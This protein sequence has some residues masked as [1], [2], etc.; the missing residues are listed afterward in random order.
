MKKYVSAALAAIILLLTVYVPSSAV[1][2]VWD[3]VSW[4]INDGVL[5]VSGASIPDSSASAAPPWSVFSDTVTAIRIGDGVTELGAR[6]FKDMSQVTSVELGHVE[7]IGE[8][9]FSGCSALETVSLPDTVRLIGDFSFTGCTSLRE[10]SLPSSVTSVGNN[11]WE[12]C[13]SL[14]SI[15]SASE[16]YYSEN[17]VLFDRAAAAI[18]KFPSGSS[19][20][21]FTAPDGITSVA[22]GAF[23]DAVNMTSVLLPNVATIA[24][25]AFYGCVSLEAVNIPSAK[26]LGRASFYGCDKLKEISFGIGLSELGDSALAFC[27]SLTSV[28]FD[29]DAPT[30]TENVFYGCSDITVSV[31]ESS[32]GFG[33]EYWLGY[34]VVRRGIYG[35]T[36]GDIEWSL[37]CN[38]GVMSLSGSGNMPSFDSPADAPWYKYRKL[39]K[40]LRI[41]GISSIGANSFRYSAL[42]SVELPECVT[43]IGAWSFSGCVDMESVSVLGQADI[44]ECAFFG[45]TVLQTAWLE[46]VTSVGAQ[47]FS[48]CTSLV[49]AL[50]G[51][52]S[53]EIGRYAFDLTQVTVLY[54]PTGTGYSTDEWAGIASAPYLAGDANGDGVFNLA[55]VTIMLKYVAGWEITVQPISSDANMDGSYSLSDVTLMLKSLAGWNV[56]MGIDL[57]R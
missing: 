38:T 40:E 30:A 49:Y 3:G 31:S 9:A 52:I 46:N 50:C 42:R 13:P 57:L 48:S 28:S 19:A 23:R 37:D 39:I 43:E 20:V 1:K 41:S 51:A 32:I 26:K 4:Q 55:D 29:G 34:P 7:S 8:M 36:L 14:Q 5:E 24:D 54:P 21:S 53:P 15:N 27:T 45:N 33:E 25:G 11:V 47:S 10:I 12:A 17:G 35:G 22:E 56:T 16:N 18:I 44:G 2:G 6:A